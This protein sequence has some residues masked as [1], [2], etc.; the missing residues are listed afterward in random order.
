MPRR[1]V[2]PVPSMRS[3]RA[4]LISGATSVSAPRVKTESSPLCDRPIPGASAA[5]IG[6]EIPLLVTQ[7]VKVAVS[8]RT[9][10][11]SVITALNTL[12]FDLSP[13]GPAFERWH[14]CRTSRGRRLLGTH[15]SG[16]MYVACVGLSAL[17]DVDRAR[18]AHAVTLTPNTIWDQESFSH[19]TFR[20]SDGTFSVEVWTR[21]TAVR[22]V[23]IAI[24]SPCYPGSP[25]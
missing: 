2:L 5:T 21:S 16:A 6:C 7:S 1:P 10:I 22:T 24:S 11:R 12:G 13:C 17:C 3:L 14:S 8:G 9:L 25:W 4:R 19:N 23:T 18:I 20:G 15:H